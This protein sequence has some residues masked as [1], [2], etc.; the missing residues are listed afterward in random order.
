MRNDIQQLATETGELK[1]RSNVRLLEDILLL[2]VILFIIVGGRVYV[3]FCVADTRENLFQIITTIRSM[4]P[5][6]ISAAIKRLKTNVAIGNLP[7]GSK[8]R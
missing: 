8:A 2:N 3:A 5:V 1:S 4:E 7:S 6:V